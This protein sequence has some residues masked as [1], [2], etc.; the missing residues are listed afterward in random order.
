M[1]CYPITK[2]ENLFE[3]IVKAGAIAAASGDLGYVIVCS[4]CGYPIKD[5]E[6]ANDCD[7]FKRAL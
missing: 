5:H 4:R 2:G 6:G 7:T 3:A 1:I